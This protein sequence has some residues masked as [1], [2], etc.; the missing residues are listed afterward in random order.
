MMHAALLFSLLGLA[1]AGSPKPAKQTKVL[2]PYEKTVLTPSSIRSFPSLSFGDV[3]KPVHSKPKC[4]TFP[5]TS[6]WPSVTEWSKFGNFL[7]GSLL[8]PEPAQAA[9][10]PG[11]LQN[12]TRCQWL[13][14]QA[15]Q[16]HFW[17]D[18]P[19]TTLTEWPQGSTCVLSANATGE[20]ERGGWPEYVVNVTSVRDVQAAVNFARNKNLRVVI[21]NT[22]HDFGG[23]SMGA[24]S[25]SIWVHNLKTFE[26]LPSFTMGK[27]TG[28]A[29]HVG[30]GIESFE[31]F[32]HMFKSNISLVGPGW[33]TVGAVGGWVSVAGHGT[34]TSK[35]GLGADQVLSINV[36]TADGQFLTV[37]PFN[38]DDLWFALRGGGGST[39]GVITSVVV[40]AYPPINTV[41]VPLNFGNIG[42]PSNS[43]DGTYPLP[44]RVATG[45]PPPNTNFMNNKPD[46]FWEGVK[47]SYHYCLKVQELGGYCFSY[48]FPLGNNSF[49]FTS[50]QIIPNITA[51][52]AI[53]ALQ[54]LYT[55]LNALSIPVSLPSSGQILP[56]LYAGNGQRTGSSNPAN[57]RYRSRLFPRKNLVDPALWNK[58]FAAIRSGVEEGGLVFHGWGYAPTCKKAGYPG[59]ENSAVH[60]AWRETVLPAA[61]M[62][63]IPA[64]WTAAQAKVNDEHTYKYT[65]VFKQL[66]SGAG[67]YMNEGDPAEKNWQDSFFGVN[68]KKLLKIKGKRDP[69]GLFWAQTTVGSEEWRVATADGY[70]AGQNGRLCRV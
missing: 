57:T 14:T 60:P 69:W 49:A 9:C 34:L 19:L 42:F 63:V 39:W 21:K 45:Q 50:N 22:G 62:E 65:D 2:F 32:N 37:D 3:S 36:V 11:P 20:C 64:R 16:T 26:Y 10:Y 46:Q 43:T 8:R 7:N 29:A 55:Q 12:Q 30:A 25:L 27:Y 33:G 61:L 68:Y 35:Y 59:C 67:S 48:I 54:P 5:G 40:K 58:T 23:R 1:A 38:H 24:G 52:E 4:R 15:G 6:D 44:I 13:V 18:E 31:L 47:I 66:T 53:A 28:P 41:T 70:P 17:L 51:S 56:T